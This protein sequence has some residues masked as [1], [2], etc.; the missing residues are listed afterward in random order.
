M[1]L[2]LLFLMFPVLLQARP[3]GYIAHNAGATAI[4]T[5]AW[6]Q[7]SAAFAPSCSS[8][9]VVNGTNQ[10]IRIGIGGSGSEVEVGYAI[11]QGAM[12]HH[13]PQPLKSGVRVV[14]RAIGANATS[15]Y[16][17]INCLQ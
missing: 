5:V 16:L 2:L 14:G 15:G 12:V 4:T 17:I 10:I 6:I 1:R 11:G 9:S 13:I 7:L 3:V 8:L